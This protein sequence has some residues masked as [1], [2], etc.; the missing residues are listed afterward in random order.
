MKLSVRARALVVGVA[1]ASLLVIPLAL[2]SAAATGASCKKASET[3]KAGVTTFLV[4]SC[5]PLAVTGGSGKGPVTGTKPGQTAGTVNVKVTWVQKKGTTSAKIKFSKNP[6]GR[7]KCP[8]AS[9]RL[10]ITGS[11]T[12]GTGVAVKTIKVGQAVTGSVCLK[13]TAI[14]LESGTVVK[15]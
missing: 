9:T 15:F 11:V 8:V 13:G 6:A 2:P 12:G 3:T 14:S 7:G 4:S 10:K 5:T 1:S